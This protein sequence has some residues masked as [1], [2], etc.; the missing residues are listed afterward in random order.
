MHAFGSNENNPKYKQRRAG[1]YYVNKGVEDLGEID[2]DLEEWS[3]L[4]YS[5]SH[6]KHDVFVARKEGSTGKDFE[7][8][9]R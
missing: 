4:I 9:G 8:F 1:K 7:S 6:L 3:S 5:P 2:Q